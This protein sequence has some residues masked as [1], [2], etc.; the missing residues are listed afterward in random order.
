M[1]LHRV[2]RIRVSNYSISNRQ[3]DEGWLDPALARLK[4]VAAHLAEVS[5]RHASSLVGFGAVASILGGCLWAVSF[6]LLELYDA[7]YDYSI[8]L[9]YDYR[10]D[11][12]HISAGMLFGGMLLFM[13]GLVGLYQHMWHLGKTGRVARAG[14]LLSAIATTFYLVTDLLQLLDDPQDGFLA[15]IIWLPPPVQTLYFSQMPG[16]LMLS[17]GLALFGIHAIK[18]RTLP[19][20]G[21][22]LFNVVSLAIHVVAFVLRWAPTYDDEF[23]FVSG[24]FSGLMVLFGICWIWLGFTLWSKGKV[25]SSKTRQASA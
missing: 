19:F 13:A 8:I 23:I 10:I 9:R 16:L 14:L 17:L 25:R 11:N 7:K 3:W 24:A 6:G 20:L 4:R 22:V 18:T 1:Q 21:V 12:L 15:S 2:R 5:H